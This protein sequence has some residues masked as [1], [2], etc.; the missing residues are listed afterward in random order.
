[1]AI[2][3]TTLTTYAQAV[4]VS[5]GTQGDAVTT[6][7][8]CNNSDDTTTFDIY[9]VPAGGTPGPANI[10]YSTYPVTGRD[11]YVIEDRL[12]LSPGDSIQALAS[13]AGSIVATVSSLS[14]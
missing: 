9:L 8:L 7:Y 13:I 1:M 11:T 6:M 3:S 2:T 12:L 10:I 5:A 14:V 4:F